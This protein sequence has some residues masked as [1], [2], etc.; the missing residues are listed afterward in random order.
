VSEALPPAFYL[1]DGGRFSST[2]LTRGPWSVDHQHGG[3]PAALMARAIERKL[4]EVADALVVRLRA[5]FPRPLPIAPLTAKAE[6]VRAGRKVQELAATLSIGDDV[7][8]RA[9]ALAVR[10]ADLPVAPGPAALAPPSPAQSEPF[11]MSFF[12]A[13]IA[14]HRG[15]EGRLA[16]GAW[17]SGA[18]AIWMRPTA[19]LVLGEAISPLSRAAIVADSGNGIGFRQDLAGMSF[20]NYDVDVALARPPEG[21]WICLDAATRA[22]SLGAGLVDVGLFDERGALGRATQCLVIERRSQ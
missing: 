19:P 8:C 20:L 2:I 18:A 9:T 3:P 7:V 15:V 4:A 12:P 10:R 16:R 1:E 13:D 21:E 22:G 14:Y 11:A 6:I 17:G 5:V